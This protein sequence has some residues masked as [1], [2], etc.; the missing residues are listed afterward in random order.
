[1][2]LENADAS[3]TGPVA[4]LWKVELYNDP[5]SLEGHAGAAAPSDVRVVSPEGRVLQ[6][7]ATERLDPAVNVS[8]CLGRRPVRGTTW[9]SATIPG[10]AG[11]LRASG[12]TTYRVEA[13]VGIEWR[14]VQLLDSGCRGMGRG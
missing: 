6:S 2:N 8:V 13:L 3:T 4:M 11:E 1:M 5:V 10:L 12:V 7:H 14:A 9:W